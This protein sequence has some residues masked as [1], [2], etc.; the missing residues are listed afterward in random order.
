[1]CWWL[2]GVLC[3]QLGVMPM[4][5]RWELN[6][7]NLLPLENWPSINWNG[8]SLFLL[9][10]P[11]FNALCV[12]FRWPAHRGPRPLSYSFWAACGVSDVVSCT[13]SRAGGDRL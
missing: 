2:F 5:R 3:R 7:R 10:Y 11:S 1:M 13:V 6:H 8:F 12:L 9:Q 4:S